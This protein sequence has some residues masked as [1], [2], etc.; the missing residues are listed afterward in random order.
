MK[1]DINMPQDYD[2]KT[3]IK[4][5]TDKLEQGIQDLF[6]S[7][8]YKKYL[9][10]MSKFH[11][12]S[13]NNI[14]LIAMQKP[15]ASH[16]AG[17]QSWQKNFER[18]VKK[19]EK[20][21]KILAPAPYQITV[22]KEVK[23]ANGFAVIGQDGRPE[24]QEVKMTVPAFKLATVFDISQTEGKELP[25]I[26]QEL[27]GN[28]KN[29]D[30]FINAV[31]GISPVPIRYENISSGAKG[32]FSSGNQ[33]I[34]IN[35]GMPKMQTVK[36]LVHELAHSKLHD[37]KSN[38]DFIKKDQRTREVEAESVA[39]TVCKYYG[40]KT[41]EYSFGYIGAWS[42]G[43]ELPELKKSLDTI[44]TVAADIIDGIDEK[45]IELQKERE[46]TKQHEKRE[47]VMG[48]LSAN[49]V[50]VAE[51]YEKRDLGEYTAEY[52]GRESGCR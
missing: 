46:T 47:S 40:L 23:D 26:V 14:I 30:L 12:Y 43:K 2:K 1:G 9:S 4:E 20:G 51:N 13:P 8:K 52:T 29:F 22:N 49:K 19:G 41:D 33:E 3:A 21:I 27:T 5:I 7:E 34:V 10:A 35:A 28:V 16:I 39:Y 18:H 15:D 45:L 50:L 31:K 6:T 32:Y 17:F 25:T 38:P 44:R 36:T 37:A 11:N 48:K 42:S 24:M